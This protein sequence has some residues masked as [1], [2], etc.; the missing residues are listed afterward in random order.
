M[1]EL[2]AEKDAERNRPAAKDVDKWDLIKTGNVC[3]RVKRA[4]TEWETR[5]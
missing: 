2:G 4:P 1:T 5:P 3:V